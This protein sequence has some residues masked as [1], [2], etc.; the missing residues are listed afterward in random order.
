MKLAI[1]PAR[2]GSKRIPG[3]NIRLF[4]GKP[5]ITYSIEAALAC[6]LFDHVIVSTD[7]QQIA[8]QAIECGAE[9]PFTRPAGLADDFTVI[10]DVIRHTIEWFSLERNQQID[11][12]CC[13]YA[14]APLIQPE[15]IRRA[16]AV[17]AEGRADFALSVC[18]FSFPIQRALKMDEQGCVSMVNP[19]YASTRS[20]DLQ[21]CYHDAAQFYAGTGDAF[22]G[23][24]TAP[25]TAGV[26]VPRNTVQDIDTEEDWAVAEQ[27]YYAY[28]Y[29]AARRHSKH[30]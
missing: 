13:I 12:A 5:I 8:D 30:E 16:M 2:G 28:R 3:K 1:V 15:S 11:Q 18:S 25:V 23:K 10:A 19:E 14:T 4:A 6:R 27:M 26:P 21:E 17:L 7:D 9:V 22:S 29:L 20:Q 24:V